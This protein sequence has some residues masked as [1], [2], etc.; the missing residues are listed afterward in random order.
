VTGSVALAGLDLT[1]C[2]EEVAGGEWE[3]LQQMEA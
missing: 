2:W 1:L 3:K